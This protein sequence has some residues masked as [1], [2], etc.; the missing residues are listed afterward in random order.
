[1]L[2]CFDFFREMSLIGIASRMVLAVVCGGFIGLEREF[3]RRTAGFRTHILICMGA[4]I[5]TLTSQYMVL[6]MKMFT[7]MARLGA[8]VIAGIGFIG[9][10]TI[11][12]TKNKRVKG[13]TTAAGMWTAAIIGLVCGAGYAECAI[14]ATTAVLI[15]EV[16]LIKLEYRFAKKVRDVNLYIEYA[17]A[18]CIESIIRM[19]KDRK[20][21]MNGLEISRVPG[22]SDE[23]Y[24]C[25]IIS[26]QANREK[27]DTEI[28]E[29]ITSIDGV[30]NI[31][32]L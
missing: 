4:A 25:A 6:E 5:T 7:D 14:A 20:V 13:L 21:K 32:E 19:L 8:Q 23:H 27:L 29:S 16:L 12:V 15:A 22:D 28:I 30:V 18:N 26:I 10:G 9:A 17:H 11:I 24:Y 3:K 31:E 1:M 2:V